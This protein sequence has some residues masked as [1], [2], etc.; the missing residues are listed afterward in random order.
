MDFQ[1]LCPF[2][3]YEVFPNIKLK[4]LFLKCLPQCRLMFIFAKRAFT[5]WSLDHIWYSRKPS[6]FHILLLKRGKKEAEVL[7]H[8]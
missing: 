2:Y 3:K 7:H 6:V 8:K 5:F 1:S 4:C